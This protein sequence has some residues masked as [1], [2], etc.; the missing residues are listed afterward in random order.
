MRPVCPAP[1]KRYWPRSTPSTCCAVEAG[2]LFR[3][4]PGAVQAQ[5]RDLV[6]LGLRRIEA[7]IGALGLEHGEH[8][9][10]AIARQ[11]E[12]GRL[13]FVIVVVVVVVGRNAD[14]QHLAHRRVGELIVQPGGDPLRL[15]RPG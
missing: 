10:D 1:A 4:G 7:A 8:A 14:R 13:R 5:R 12:F 9:G 6:G 15:R 11:A 3:R 2:E